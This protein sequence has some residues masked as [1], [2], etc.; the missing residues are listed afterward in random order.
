VLKN[1]IPDLVAAVGKRSLGFLCDL[2]GNA[3][4]ISQP[5]S[6]PQ[7]HDLSYVWRPAIED[8]G[9][10]L[11]LGLK[12]MLVPAVRDA[13]E[14]LAQKDSSRM[15]ELVDE[16][17]ER[18]QSW[19]I[20]RRIV[21]HLLR[22]VRSST[23]HL[24][25][26][27]LTDR[28]LFDEVGVR[29]EYLLLM[30]EHFGKL[31]RKEQETI[32]GWIGEG[33][34][35]PYLKAR[36]EQFAGRPVTDD[37]VEQYRDNWRRERLEPIAAYL[38]G[39]WK[40]RYDALAKETPV[41]QHPEFPFYTT[42]GAFGPSSPKTL[43]ELNEMSAREL[44]DYLRNWQPTAGDP[45]HGETPE[46][47]GRQV[48]SLISANPQKY[49]TE[50]NLFALEE[51]TYVR[52]VLWGFRDAQAQGRMFEWERVLNLCAWAAQH[53]REI[54]NRQA[55]PLDLLDRDPNWA[56][57]RKTIIRLL[58][59][60]LEKEAG[61][62]PFGLR[63]QVWKALEPLTKDP[64]PSQEDEERYL[65]GG[66]NQEYE[67]TGLRA[68][69]LDVM[70]YSINTARGEAMQAVVRYALWVRRNSEKQ[71][72]A[73]ELTRKGFDAMPEVRKV[74]DERL[75]PQ[76]EPSLAVRSVYGR[77]FPWLYQLDPAWAGDAVNRIFPT[78][79]GLVNHWEAAWEGYI[80]SWPA[81]DEIADV[82]REQYKAA[83][84]RIG[85][86]PE[87]L[88]RIVNLD[89]RLGRHLVTLHWRGKPEYDSDLLAGFYRK[90]SG[91]LRGQTMNFIG[92]SLH[93]DKGEVPAGILDRM[94]S[95]WK[96]RLQ[97]AQ[98]GGAEGFTEELTQFGWW[99]ICG[100]FDDDWVMEQLVSAL[101]ISKG[102]QPE[103]LVVGRLAELCNKMPSP[104]IECLSL[105]IEGDRQG[106]GI[107]GWQEDA[108]KT[109]KCVLESRDAGARQSA[110]DLANRLGSLGHFGFVQLLKAVN[111]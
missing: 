110:V 23:P 83:V 18:G 45:F 78:D 11:N 64:E 8:H 109:I 5:E 70:T 99:F 62:I 12:P 41:P 24:V 57:A 80:G 67:A 14:A 37:E 52:S 30:K 33:P 105:I 46:G 10:N 17:E 87:K 2:L 25:V 28:K 100:K 3:I 90:A 4:Q 76:E 49:A 29:H 107:L 73:K 56:E 85:R 51:P 54:P 66:L 94:R 50:T 97:T 31:A 108:M 32:L 43:D 69:S 55:G 75:D 82:L 6:T 1:N 9:Q 60:G 15:G 88:E 96:L 111:E 42:G 98:A 91:K 40:A 53:P 21:L 22:V 95:F 77:A 92:W 19:L 89:E 103:H 68:R 84:Q 16:L 38:E 104:A 34:S 65:F 74:L 61:M 102:S 81:Y 36:L 101:R 71:P 106:W 47:L 58:S 79:A 93:Q 86:W 72:N 27:R 44:A 35:V 13:A 7:P 63:D 59:Q 48:T 20:F 39:D 26:Q